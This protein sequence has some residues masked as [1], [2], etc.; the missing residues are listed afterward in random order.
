MDYNLCDIKTVEAV[1]KKYGFSFSKSLGQN[2][3]IDSEVCPKMAE[4]LG[5]DEKTLVIEIG[6]GIGVLTKELCKTA[7]KVAAI[8]LDKRL[9]PVLEETL[10]DFDN[11]ELIEGDAMKLDLKALISEKF[12]GYEKV[13]V[14]ANLPYY[15]TS[16][17]IMK[18]LESEL[19]ICEILVMVQKEA[20]ERLCANPG[21]RNSG[22]VSAAVKFYGD[23]EILFEVGR[24]SFMPSPKVDSAVIKI[25]LNEENKYNVSD[26]KAFFSFVRAAFAQRR[27]TLVNS[28]SSS[29]SISKN[30]I[31][32]AL[33]AL[34]INRSIRAEQLTMEDL[35]NLSDLLFNS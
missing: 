1:L 13:K 14:C 16:P 15:I 30:E 24:E 35:V 34:S 28:V 9:Y 8:E 5:A 29:L 33:D 31:T 26:K 2:F 22:A 17:I 11:F 20:A 23:A 18:L 27:K 10:G 6:P 32:N 7:G 12:S 3:L 19:P 21:T 4:F 25:T